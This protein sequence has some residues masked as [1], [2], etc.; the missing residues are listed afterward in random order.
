MFNN[1]RYW[2][3]VVSLPFIVYLV[4]NSFGGFFD[5]I[6]HIFDVDNQLLVIALT[7]VLSAISINVWNTT[8]LNRYVPCKHDNVDHKSSKLSLIMI[9]LF[10]FGH[11]FFDKFLFHDHGSGVGLFALWMH[12]ITD[13][14]ILLVLLSNWS[15]YI[16]KNLFSIFGFRVSLWQVGVVVAFFSILFLS[17][18]GVLDLDVETPEIAHL[19]VA[20]LNGFLLSM[21]VHLPH[22]HHH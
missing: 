6:A 5:E 18:S 17:E 14:F 22:R 19:L 20:L 15:H 10:F 21:F 8:G 11:L 13:V 7:L 12:R 16:T 3:E 9:T 4:F 2:I 1:I